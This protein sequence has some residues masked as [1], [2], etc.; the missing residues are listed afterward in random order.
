MDVQCFPEGFMAMN[1]PVISNLER[2]ITKN[3]D[4]SQ[5]EFLDAAS[6]QMNSAS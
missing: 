3:P 2:Q 1:Q 4:P 6:G 5:A